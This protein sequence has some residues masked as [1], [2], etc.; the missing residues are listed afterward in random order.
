MPATVTR[1]VPP[2]VRVVDPYSESSIILFLSLRAHR[3]WN[4][5]ER[6]RAWRC[7]ARRVG[8]YS[9]FLLTDSEKVHIVR[10]A[11]GTVGD[12]YVSR[13]WPKHG[14]REGYGNDAFRG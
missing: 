8:H 3:T 2:C 13:L 6:A 14:C 7:E 11:R 5:V 9:E 1:E 10:T 4:E 12:R